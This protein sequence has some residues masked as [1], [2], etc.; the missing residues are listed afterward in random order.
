MNQKQWNDAW[1]E[2]RKEDIDRFNE[3]SEK[4]QT[5]F[6]NIRALHNEVYLEKLSFFKNFL[7]FK[8]SG[9][10]AAWCEIACSRKGTQSSTSR[11]I[12]GFI[13]FAN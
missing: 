4:I 3:Q 5:E 7:Q 11:A 9:C 12:S 8:I 2:A 13:R 1:M 10:P 6:E